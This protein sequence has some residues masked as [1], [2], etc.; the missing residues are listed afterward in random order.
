MFKS[1]DKCFVPSNVLNE[2]ARERGLK[3]DQIAQYGLPIRKGFWCTSGDVRKDSPT[4][5]SNPISRFKNVLHLG[6][7]SGKA[8]SRQ[9]EEKSKPR[10]R[11]STLRSELGLNPNLPTVLVVGGGDGMGGIA[12][13]A[14]ALGTKLG[15]I[16]DEPSY[17]MVVVC[18]NN[19]EAKETL[20]EMYWG[21]G[22]KVFV[23]GFVNNM[24]EWMN[25]S[26]ALVTKAGPGTIAEASICGL[27][28]MLFA[29]LPGQEEGNIP[30][31][32]DAGFGKYS[33]DPL[34]IADTVSSWLS[35]PE[36]MESMR[37]AALAAARPS[38]TLDI[39]RELA[40]L[41]FAT[42]KQ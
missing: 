22:V 28:C 5:N 6:S 26:D 16:S 37:N 31:V 32:E 2:A 42:R 27:P 15:E 25:A 18:G 17:Q 1:V 4:T 13:I 14:K 24:D 29:Y 9:E 8:E 34:V 38:A 33:G 7:K 12:E 23:Q 10:E 21:K 20:S 19:K 3:S 30:F 41:A 11:C 39:A 35:S 40:E 36:K